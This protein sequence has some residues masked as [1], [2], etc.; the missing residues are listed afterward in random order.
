MEEGHMPLAPDDIPEH[1][2]AVLGKAWIRPLSLQSDF[3]RQ[4]SRE[5]ALAASL[6]YIST[7]TPDGKDHLA[8][9]R[10]TELGLRALKENMQQC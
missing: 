7:L 8:S 6:G 3:T 5:V 9:W 4:H 2:W 10:I 1:L